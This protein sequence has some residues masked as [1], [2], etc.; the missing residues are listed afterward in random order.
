MR[1]ALAAAAALV[2]MGASPG[3]VP[4]PSGA[5]EILD[6]SVMPEPL[7][8][9]KPLSIVVHTAADVISIQGRV[10]SFKFTVPK[11]ADGTFSV[12]GRV[13]WFARLYHGS[14]QMTFIATDTSGTHAETTTTVRI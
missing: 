8:V 1:F 14:F 3:P 12:R 11:S 13:P 7:R 10:L 9:G 2:L 4:V 6:V 5:P